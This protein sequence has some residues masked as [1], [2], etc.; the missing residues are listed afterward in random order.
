MAA[1]AQLRLLTSPAP[2]VPVVA[3]VVV[4][5][6]GATIAR[7]R[8][9]VGP[10]PV[11]PGRLPTG[12]PGLDEWLKGWPRPGLVEVA[13][14]LGSGRLAVVLPSL[15]RLAREGRTVAVID[16]ECRFHP[17][18]LGEGEWARWVLVRPSRERAA[19]AAEQVA[20][21]GAVDALLLLDLPPLGRAGLRIGR[22]T[23]AGAMAVFVVAATA[24]V[25]VPAG[26]RLR[27]DGWEG[28]TRLRVACTR[29]RDGRMEGERRL[30]LGG[31]VARFPGRSAS[32]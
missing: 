29:S 19:W 9:L 7:L 12:V 21:S 5:P 30:E 22:A 8:A 11:G 20:R 2:L 1:P 13:G 27:V 4:D 3:P 31:A 14:A 10:S 26:I 15:V 17:P 28:P 24:E 23:E 6:R 25:D 16:P 18:G 32:P